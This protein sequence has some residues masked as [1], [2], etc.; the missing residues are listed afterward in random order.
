MFDK[1]KR[2]EGELDC[3]RAGHAQEQPESDPD[4]D[5]D[6]ECQFEKDCHFETVYPLLMKQHMEKHRIGQKIVEQCARQHDRK[7]EAG[8]M[9]PQQA[10]ACK[11]ADRYCHL[12]LDMGDYERSHKFVKEVFDKMDTEQRISFVKYLGGRMISVGQYIETLLS[13]VQP[14]GMIR[15]G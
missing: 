15:I 8:L 1:K 10:I 12:T 4:L 5:I 13:Q 6:Q 9:T 11:M 2:D 14:H 3:T 7:V